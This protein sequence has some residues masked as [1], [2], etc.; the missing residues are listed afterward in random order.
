MNYQITFTVLILLFLSGGNAFG[1]DD[2]M[3]CG[4]NLIALEDTMYEV[5]QSCGEPYSEKV[6]GEKTSY[7]VYKKKRLGVESVLY[8]TEWVYER[9]DG[10]YIL[11][12]EGSRLVA[13][14]F[15]FQ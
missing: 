4:S 6:V 9:S 8:V 15:V 5:R 1:K 13:K 12:F 3:R 11:T 7:R 2:S 10:I 14:E